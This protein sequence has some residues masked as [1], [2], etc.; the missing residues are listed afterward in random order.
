MAYDG[1]FS[2]ENG[3]KQGD[4]SALN[5]LEEQVEATCNDDFIL[6]SPA[7]RTDA[8]VHQHLSAHDDS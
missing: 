7:G 4:H 3:D 1:H 8:G 2:D 5:A 6:G